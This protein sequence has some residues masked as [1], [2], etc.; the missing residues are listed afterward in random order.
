VWLL[1]GFALGM[2][3]VAW[4]QTPP[5]PLAEVAR[6]EAERRK[7]IKTPAKIYTN[8]DVAKARGLMTS[9]APVASVQAPGEAAAQPTGTAGQPAPG[10]AGEAAT[11]AAPPP[12]AR[13]EA[14]WRA[15]MTEAREKVRRSEMFAEALQT[16]INSLTNDFFRW[17]DPYQREQINQQRNDALAEL[18]RVKKEI[19][20]QNQAIAD[21]EEEARRA[22]VPPGWLR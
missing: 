11:A 10:A 18:E 17:D 3:T 14:Y 5:P 13:D 9:A 16:R 6:K 7:G 20:E 19:E 15:R 21:L 8:E 4:A 2:G 12:A 1:V 22:G